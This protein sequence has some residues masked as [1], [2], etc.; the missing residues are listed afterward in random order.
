VLA[1][2]TLFSVRSASQ[3]A[4]MVVYGDEGRLGAMERAATFDPANYR[5]RMLLGYAWRNR[6]R[7]DLA[8]PHAERAARLF[9]NHRAPKQLLS[10][11]R[12]R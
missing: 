12:S 5:I 7:C 8:R 2:G 10:T 3:L 4:S 9:P 6:G 11:C 1:A